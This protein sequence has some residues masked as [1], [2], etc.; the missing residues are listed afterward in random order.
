[1]D[2]DVLEE[3]F[4]VDEWPMGIFGAI[5]YVNSR[6]FG[7]N[8]TYPPALEVAFTLVAADYYCSFWCSWGAVGFEI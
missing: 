2:V 4:N 8:G 1:M 3:V 5:F 7:S 6:F